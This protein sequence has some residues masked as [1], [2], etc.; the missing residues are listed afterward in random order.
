MNIQ[1]ELKAE[2][3]AKTQVD[4][5]CFVKH[6]NRLDGRMA[7]GEEFEPAKQPPMGSDLNPFG[8]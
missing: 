3:S 1:K 5:K 7:R 8:C 4:A 2:N 6:R